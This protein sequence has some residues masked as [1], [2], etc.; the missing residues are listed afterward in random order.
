MSDR[1][2]NAAS[3]GARNPYA[4]AELALGR[5]IDWTRIVDAK[6][7]LQQTLGKPYEQLFDPKFSSPV[8]AGAR[9]DP[10][11]AQIQQ[12]KADAI[13]AAPTLE[14]SVKALRGTLPEAPAVSGAPSSGDSH[15]PN[16]KVAT[17]ER[18][19]ITALANIVRWVDPGRF[20]Q[21]AAQ[22]LDVIQG[23]AADCYFLAAL[24]A[25]AWAHPFAIAQRTRPSAQGGTFANATA[26][27]MIP[28]FEGAAW[29]QH[30]VSELIPM[31]EPANT[32]I[33]V[34]AD[35]LSETWPCVYEKAY[36]QLRSGSSS[37]TPNMASLDYGDAVL[38]LKQIT[39][40]AGDYYSTTAD[41]A[42]AIYERVRA[43][44]LSYKTFNPMVAWTYGTAPAGVNYASAAIV[45]NHAYSIL[46][47]SYANGQQY[48]V[49]RNPWGAYEATLDVETGTWMAYDTTYWRAVPLA[50]HGIFALRAD[51]FKQYFA[52]YGRVSGAGSVPEF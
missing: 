44:S 2:S 7:L 32:Y 5:T 11:T 31:L 14:E 25:V 9:V 12:N 46:G 42:D 16:G 35:D 10:K 28:Y 30:Q 15:G 39:G 3:I 49:L 34:R 45:A 6:E 1:D 4:L 38:A 13:Y 48:V 27:D 8:F 33:Y 26:V 51:I 19:V 37:D 43:N 36:A 41:T 21:D 22:P 40:L 29:K 47:W 20:F 50:A 18:P 17:L 24:A 23:S 52:G